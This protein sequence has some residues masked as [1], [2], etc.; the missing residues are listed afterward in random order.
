MTNNLYNVTFQRRHFW[1]ETEGEWGG[2]NC[3]ETAAEDA[4]LPPSAKQFPPIPRTE[5]IRPG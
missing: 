3:G 2:R 5:G 1:M 4:H